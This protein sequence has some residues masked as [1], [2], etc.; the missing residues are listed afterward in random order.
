M[1]DFLDLAIQ[2]LKSMS[3]KDFLAFV[4]KHGL[5]DEDIVI[6]DDVLAATGMPTEPVRTEL[7]EWANTTGCFPANEDQYSVAA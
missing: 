2:E 6:H 3:S 7:V 5:L 1:A 4:Q